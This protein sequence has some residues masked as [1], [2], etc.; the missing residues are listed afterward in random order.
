[1]G[2]DPVTTVIVHPEPGFL[3]QITQEL[4][5]LADNPMHVEYVMWPSPGLRIPEELYDR[6]VSLS[7]PDLSTGVPAPFGDPEL[8]K[9]RNQALLDPEVLQVLT[10]EEL[11]DA[12]GVEVLPEGLN[13]DAVQKEPV[14]AKRKP[15]RP[16][17]E[18][19]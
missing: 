11:K 19:L 18:A 13:F 7:E 17:K 12:T 1:V 10:P 4:L 6:W 14:P 8:M 3:K 2:G 16:K 5:V 9:L 15:G